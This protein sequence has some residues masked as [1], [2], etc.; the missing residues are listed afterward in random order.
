MQKTT[1]KYR[2]I[3]GEDCSTDQTASIVREYAEKYP[4]KITAI[5]NEKNLGVVENI[6]QVRDV[7][8][9]KYVA[10]LEGDDYWTDPLKLQKQ[11]DF[12]EANEDYVCVGGKV[13]ILDTRNENNKMQ[14]GDQYFEYSLNQKAP[15]V[16]ALDKVKLPFHTSTYLF[17]RNALDLDL[18][19][20]LFKH[21]ISGDVPILNMLN[22]KGSI[23]YINDEFGVQHHNSGGITTTAEHKGMNFLWNRVY[24]WEHISSLYN[25][26]Y[27]KSLAIEN[28]KY[29]KRIFTKKFLNMK[30]TNQIRFYRNSNILHQDLV[31]VIMVTVVQKV[32][33]KLRLKR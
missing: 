1:F 28:K 16:A 12:L 8:A 32:L 2:L 4:E 30:L 17:L 23:Y 13:K 25:Q 10:M 9:A 24:M 5:I 15:K 14:Y 7:I 27:L 6:R 29:F 20:S 18:L 21:S 11:V 19:E 3:I 33:I 26:E 31:K 22:A